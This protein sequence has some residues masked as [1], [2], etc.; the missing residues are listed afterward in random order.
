[1]GKFHPHGDS[2]IYDALEMAQPFSYRYELVDGH[3]NFGS[4][5]GSGC[6]HALY[7]SKIN[8]LSHGTI[9]GY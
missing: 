9:A 6:C 8:P 2:A 3:G 4:V 7:G 1:M 5:D